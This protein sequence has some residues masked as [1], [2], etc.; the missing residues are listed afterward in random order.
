MQFPRLLCLHLFWF[1]FW[2]RILCSRFKIILKSHD[3]PFVRVSQIECNLPEKAFYFHL[4]EEAFHFARLTFHWLSR[5]TRT[6]AKQEK[7]V[8]NCCI[9]WLILFLKTRKLHFETI[10][11]AIEDKGNHNVFLC[12]LSSLQSGSLQPQDVLLNWPSLFQLG[13]G[14]SPAK[15]V[16]TIYEVLVQTSV[17]DVG[18]RAS[19]FR[20]WK[21]EALGM[22]CICLLGHFDGRTLFG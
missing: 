4:P 20:A 5:S 18:V 6:K 19:V 22:V 2:S 3:F 12:S 7:V 17:R 16:F 11:L 10:P 1:P 8:L 9:T 15:F 13:S 21:Q 14:P